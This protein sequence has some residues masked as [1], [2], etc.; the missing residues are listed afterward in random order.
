MN[1]LPGS[2]LTG[3]QVRVVDL[4]STFDTANLTITRNGNKINGATADLTVSTEDAAIGLVYTGATY[5]WKLI[6]NF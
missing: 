1:A 6:E 5:G 4:A 3:D 2:P